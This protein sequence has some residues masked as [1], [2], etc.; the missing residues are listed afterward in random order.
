MC[1]YNSKCVSSPLPS[2]PIRK[3]KS[4][5]LRKHIQVRLHRF[6]RRINEKMK[7]EMEFKNLKLY[8]ENMNILKENAE[9]WKK[10]IQLREENTV[11]LSELAKKIK[12]SG[13]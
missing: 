3:M 10:A 13:S 7:Q 1:T 11:L 8:M 5:R 12:P 6:N 9:L 2:S 4:N